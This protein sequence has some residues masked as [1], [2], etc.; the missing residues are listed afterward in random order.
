MTSTT[1]ITVP[2]LAPS[3]SS[4]RVAAAAS[5]AFAFCFFWTVA[6]VDVPHKAS[7]A[8]LLAWWQDSANRFSGTVSC[9]F[10]VGAAVSFAVVV[11]HLRRLPAFAEAPAWSAFARSMGAAFTA[12]LLVSSA[13]RGVIGYLVNRWD[14]LLPSVEVLRYSTG[15][16]YLLMNVPVMAALSLTILAISVI[17][18][19]TAALPRWTAYVGLLVTA[20][21]LGAVALQM[22]AYTIAATLLWAICVGIALW[23]SS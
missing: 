23:R 21:V 6:S 10:A 22:G 3:R 20:L 16:N 17:T 1:P 11:N 15:L 13:L 14:Q 12:T 2:H 18:M 7:D 5:A 9:F 19:R 4:G 8:E